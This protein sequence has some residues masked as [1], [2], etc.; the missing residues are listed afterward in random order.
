MVMVPILGSSASGTSTDDNS[1]NTRKV[2]DRIMFPFH[3]LIGIF[4]GHPGFLLPVM[5]CVP[6][7]VLTDFGKMFVIVGHRWSFPRISWWEN[8]KENLVFHGKNTGF[9]GFSYQHQ[10]KLVVVCYHGLGNLRLSFPSSQR[11]DARF[12]THS[13]WVL[14]DGQFF[15]DGQMYLLFIWR[16]TINTSSIIIIG[17]WLTWYHIIINDN[18]VL[19]HH[20]HQ[21]LVTTIC[22]SLTMAIITTWGN[23]QIIDHYHEL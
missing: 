19:S 15:R 16:I 20:Y 2:S 9:Y 21:Y 11:F 10:W 1:S 7:I 23:K 12:I 14:T 22:I 18:I 5:L 3:R 13:G 8:L 6:V 4:N 17:Q